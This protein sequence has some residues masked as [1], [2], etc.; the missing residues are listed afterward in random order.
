M[1]RCAL[2]T[3]QKVLFRLYLVDP[4]RPVT[5]LSLVQIPL[6]FSE[7]PFVKPGEIYQLHTLT[8]AD[9][10]QYYSV[11]VR[12]RIDIGRNCLW[13]RLYLERYYAGKEKL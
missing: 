6:K 8:K 3:F 5:D 12:P 9:F 11:F 4:T 2:V 7:G 13:T 10:I 1:A